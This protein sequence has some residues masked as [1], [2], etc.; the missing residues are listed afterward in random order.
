MIARKGHKVDIARTDEMIQTSNK[1]CR[2]CVYSSSA[3]SGTNSVICWYYM[4]EGMHRNCPVGWC[5]KYRKGISDRINN[6]N[7]RERL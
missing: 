5:D 1:L 2:T 6:Y 4:D 3:M 7:N